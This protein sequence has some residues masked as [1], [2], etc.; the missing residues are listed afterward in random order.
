[1]P[2]EVLESEE[3]NAPSPTLPGTHGLYEAARQEWSRG[4]VE[5][6]AR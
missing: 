3:W 5:P 1:L 2:D 4:E 6:T